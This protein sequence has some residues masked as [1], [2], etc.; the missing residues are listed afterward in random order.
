MAFFFCWSFIHSPEELYN[1][2]TKTKEKKNTNL[3]VSASTAKVNLLC[4][5]WQNS[6]CG[7]RTLSSDNAPES[8]HGSAFT[9]GGHTL[10]SVSP[11]SKPARELVINRG[12][13]FRRLLF[14]MMI[15]KE[16]NCTIT[17][18][19][20][21]CVCVYLLHTK[22]KKTHNTSKVRTFFL[23]TL[24]AFVSALCSPVSD[25]FDTSFQPPFSTSGSSTITSLASMS[26]WLH[27]RQWRKD[28]PICLMFTN[29]M[30]AARKLNRLLSIT[31]YHQRHSHQP[32][33]HL[34]A[35]F[36]ESAPKKKSDFSIIPPASSHRP[37]VSWADYDLA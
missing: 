2:R 10:L 36:L 13:N 12:G 37:A 23:T 26:Q 22:Y 19:V 32:F 14:P 9:G 21:V 28:P 24:K 31:F 17:L 25:R 15:K 6:Q 34:L 4:Y 1:Q 3:S 27:N 30:S 18:V 5:Q 11:W 35:V 16:Y 20:C 8:Q 29:R 7:I 33:Q